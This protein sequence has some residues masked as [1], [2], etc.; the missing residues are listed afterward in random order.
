M[1]DFTPGPY[2]VWNHGGGHLLITCTGR[3]KAHPHEGMHIAYVNLPAKGNEQW[4]PLIEA[5]ARLLA[6]A[7][8]MHEAL[9]AL[10]VSVNTLAYCYANRPENFAAALE[11]ATRDAAIARDL[12]AR[13]KEFAK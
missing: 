9:Q 5:N 1:T 13:V 7:P 11:G 2:A 4:I 6:A 8:D 12:L 3:D 10:E